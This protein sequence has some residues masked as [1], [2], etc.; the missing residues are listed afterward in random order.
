MNDTPDNIE[1]QRIQ[2][3]EGESLRTWAQKLDATPEQIKEAI[4]AVG[5]RADDVEAHL[6]G[7]RSSSNSERVSKALSAKKG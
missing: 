3:G 7:V 6:K 1:S 2:A 4:Q 5:D